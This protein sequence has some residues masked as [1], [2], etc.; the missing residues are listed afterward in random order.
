MVFLDTHL[1]YI[2][3]HLPAYA[4]SVSYLYIIYNMYVYGQV[5][6]NGYRIE[7]EEIEVVLATH[8]SIEQAVAIVRDGKIV[9]YVR[10]VP[11]VALGPSDLADLR[12]FAGRSLTHY[13]MP[14]FVK[15]KYILLLITCGDAD[16]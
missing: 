15:C 11:G 8:R 7:L 16:L 6:V 2:T 9:A 3:H 4:L 14:R 10:G 12:A 13:M 1:F 5:K